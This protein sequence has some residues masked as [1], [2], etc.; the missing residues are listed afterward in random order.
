[1][2]NSPMESKGFRL[3]AS[4]GALMG[5]CFAGLLPASA[6]DAKP[7]SKPE[8]PEAEA[9]TDASE[10]VNWVDF[11]VGGNFLRGSRAQFQQQN[12]TPA[13]GAYGGIEAFHFELPFSQ[14]GLFTIDGRGIFDNN[15]YSIRIGATDP[16][17]GY[18]RIGHVE[19]RTYYDGTGGYLPNG[20]VIF[21]KLFDNSLAVDRAQTSFEAGLTLPNKP[22]ISFR[23]DL[24]TRN[25]DKPSTIWG[26][27]TLTPGGA[28][29]RIVPGLRHFDESRHTFSL[30]VKHDIGN[31]TVGVGGR[32]E[33]Q[34]NDDGRSV[35]QQPNE[36][37]RS[38]LL[39]TSEGL[40]VNLGNV[41]AWTD[42]RLSDQWRFT[43][44]YS[45]TT[46]H[47]VISGDRIN[48][49]I[50][51]P[52]AATDTR[53]ANLY[54]GSDLKQHVANVNLMYSPSTNWYIVPSIRVERQNLDGEGYFNSIT[55]TA[56]QTVSPV[57]QFA[58]ND[59]G[60]LYVSEALDIRYNGF[61]NWALYA[62]A[63]LSQDRADL[64]EQF[65]T[66]VLNAATIFR[67]TDWDRLLQ[68]YTVG[69][70]WYA[71][72]T[73]NFGTQ[74]YHRISENEYS[75]PED[76]TSNATN[77]NNRYPAYLGIQD[78]EIDCVNF[79]VTWKPL[80]RLAF[81]SRY[82]FQ[83]STAYTE[84][85]NL[86]GLESARNKRHMFGE[87]ITWTPLNWLYT[88]G[89]VNY[90]RDT[91]HSPVED[92]TGA[93]SGIIQSAPNNYWTAGGTLGFILDAKTDLQTSY[94]HYEADNYVDNSAVSIP[95]GAGARQD[96]VSST[97]VR[98]LSER[99]RWTLR[100][101]Y[102]HYRDQ[103]S[104][105]AMNYEAHGLLST[106]QYRF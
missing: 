68:K 21:N 49:A 95:Y 94:T 81:V 82:D 101:A 27:T 55:G 71:S 8:K 80:P 65:G 86:P 60:A 103:T 75:N 30:D 83:L 105:G 51:S 62:R 93:M 45:F 76:S 97:L 92:F 37:T 23:Y 77:S 6:E 99:V 100:Y 78:F 17:K 58:N 84:V 14:R 11:G 38:R 13:T 15:D 104:G 69:A 90:V 4:S 50:V 74:Y 3:L 57:T 46:L 63:E 39:S 54:G 33:V 41:R 102:S 52:L 67:K 61:K 56:T 12:G 36:G 18:I 42:T 20:N 53:F 34:Y 5:A 44:G 32:Y 88:Q 79:R 87:T 9:E 64:R 2:K 59:R 31:T 43:T 7:T 29:R 28:Q 91:T 73:L 25:G 40:D 48:T 19:Y 89:H 96:E 26:N 66:N 35:I 24:D 22:Q 98:K 1:M 72:R 70:N 85:E 16:D 47:S 10:L 106:I